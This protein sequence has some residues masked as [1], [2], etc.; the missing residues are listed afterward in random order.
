VA[1]PT[2]QRFFYQ[3]IADRFEGLDHRHDIRT[4]LEV[5]FED[6]LGGVDLDGKVVLDAGCG[7]GAFSRWA[8]TRGARVVSCDIADKLARRAAAEAGSRGVASDA[9]ELGFHDESFEIVI[10]SEM[11]EHTERPA[12]AVR[13]LAR[14]L[15][16]G[17]VLVITTPN[18]AWQG[19]VRLA[20]RLHLRPFH[21]LE[22][23]VSWRT[24]HAAC[25]AA[26]VDVVRHVG[27]HAWPFHLGFARLSRAVDRRFGGHPA[28]CLMINQ[29]L[30]AR[31][32]SRARPRSRPA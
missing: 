25:T 4:R 10:S 24:L 22:N 20:S 28:A 11:I 12:E 23:F 6:L 17:G 13:E 29:A 27:F 8:A 1:Q 32:P 31:K 18:R 16:P 19:L 5:V 9:C 30:L 21:G 3:T 26:G 14:V 15:R 2:S 7:Y